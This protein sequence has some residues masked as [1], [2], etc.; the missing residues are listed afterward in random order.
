MGVSPGIA[1]LEGDG[2]VSASIGVC[3]DAARNDAPPGS[4]SSGRADVTAWREAVPSICARQRCSCRQRRSLGRRRRQFDRDASSHIADVDVGVLPPA[5]LP[6]RS[7]SVWW[8]LHRCTANDR[9]RCIWLRPGA[10]TSCHTPGQ[11]RWP[12][13]VDQLASR[14]GAPQG[15]GSTVGI[16]AEGTGTS[17][18]SHLKTVGHADQHIPKRSEGPERSGGSVGQCCQFSLC[19]FLFVTSRS[20]SERQRRT[21]PA[22]L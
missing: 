2:R 10:A 17:A 19:P 9:A 21:D 11:L 12:S 16:R 15:D 8:W 4:T 5:H 14:S 6:R 20:R 18:A 1:D 7:R 13:P 22:C 3:G